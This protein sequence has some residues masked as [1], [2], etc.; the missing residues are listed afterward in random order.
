MQTKL[1]SLKDAAARRDWQGA[2]RIAAKFADLGEHKAA[3]VRGHEAH[4]NA[5]FAQQL[6]RDPQGDI[7]AG[8]LAL[9]ARY[10]LNHDGSPREEPKAYS[11]RGNCIRAARKALG[12][13]AQQGVQ[14]TL[15]KTDAGWIW[16]LAPAPPVPSEA[17]T[18][19][20]EAPEAV[21]APEKPARAS[22][23]AVIAKR[24]LMLSEADARG[25]SAR[26]LGAMQAAAAGEL[27]EPPDFS[28]PTHVSG[29]KW[30]A[31]AVALQAAGDIEGLRALVY[32]PEGSTGGALHRFVR[33]SIS[34][35][36][37]KAPAH[38]R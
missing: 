8:V 28:K 16:A 34:A 17:P 25:F 29:R 4:S 3:I 21:P 6:G 9:C 10:R 31:E 13:G 5:R 1:Q 7:D 24:R 36:E 14:F 27:P 23:E 19:V 26:W 12:V 22:S 33:F 37:A 18:P 32:D 20:S 15:S 2:L 11:V 30:L 35:L 38:A